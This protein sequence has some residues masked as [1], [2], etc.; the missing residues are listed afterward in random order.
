M[1]IAVKYERIDL[2]EDKYIFKPVGIVRG[3]YNEEEEIFVTDYKEECSPIN[4]S[5]PFADAYFGCLTSMRDLKM[6]FPELSDEEILEQFFDRVNLCY[7]VGYYEYGTGTIQILNIPFESL[8]QAVSSEEEHES[9]ESDGEEVKITFDIE[10]LKE[11]R[12]IKT[13]GEIRERLDEIISTAESMKSVNNRGKKETKPTEHPAENKDK[14]YSLQKEMSRFMS[15]GELREEVKSVIK[16]QD[17]A[18]D[19]VTRGIV[20][21]Q[22]SS[23]PRHKSHML[24]YGPS[25]TGKT[26]MVNIIC[27][28]LGIPF[29][30]ADATAYT[31]EG[32]VGKSVYSMFNGL[33]DSAGGDVEKAQNGILVI[34]EID[35]KLS[36]RKDDVAGI[37]VLNS[38]LKIM[39]RD[40]IEVETSRNQTIRFDTSN[41][42][43]IF[44]GAFADVYKDKE[45]ETEKPKLIGFATAP[46]ET[47]KK[48]VEV[49]TEDLLK[50][51]MPPEFLGRIPIVTN[52]EELKLEDLVEILYRSKGGAIDE[53]R[54]FCK[55]LGIT[56]KF[57]D[58]Y[59]RE[60]ARKAYESKTG[61]RNLRKLVRESLAFAYDEILSGKSVKVLKITKKTAIDGKDY[62]T[63]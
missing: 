61:A 32:Y 22:M 47:T 40:V 13:L 5:N 15:L 44:M 52:T 60:I 33:I 36:T 17:R 30:K 20:V 54:E 29:F 39:D 59:I 26:E 25:G 24:I 4:G 6:K 45:K 18:V 11:L 34:D 10:K 19:A 7:T 56:I 1:E 38:L 42:T 62:Y 8:L 12:Q 35:K 48:K 63:E 46:E 51:G 3:Y 9:Y 55:G 23:N 43:I 50:A 16:G 2:G 37:D 41:L 14:S 58:P 28:K 49:T 21:N 31:K 57:T 27:R 53:E